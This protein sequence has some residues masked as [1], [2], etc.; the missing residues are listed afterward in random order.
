MNSINLL[1]SILVTFTPIEY[2]NESCYVEPPTKLELYE[3]IDIK[4][5]EESVYLNTMYVLSVIRKESQQECYMLIIYILGKIFH[6][7]DMK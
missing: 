2:K 4:I 5:K 6:I 1:T 3:S 7:R